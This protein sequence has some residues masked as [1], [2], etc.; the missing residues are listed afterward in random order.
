MI[1]PFTGGL[2]ASGDLA[3]LPGVGLFVTLTTAGNDA[4]GQVDATT[5]KATKIIDDLGAG[6]LYGL[7]YRGGSLLAFGDETMLRINPATKVV[8]LQSSTV[9]AYGAAT[10]P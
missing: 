10:G 6:Q 8:S 7:A 2:S 9:A 3:W 4:L 1:G 5:G